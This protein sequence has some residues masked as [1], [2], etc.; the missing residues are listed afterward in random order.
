M[1]VPPEPRLFQPPI[2][3]SRMA[4]EVASEIVTSKGWRHRRAKVTMGDRG[5][6]GF[7]I[8]G[9]DGPDLINEV[10][11]GELQVAMSNPGSILTLALNG[12]G[13]F[14]EPVAVRAIT[15][16]QS[17]DQL[18]FAVKED[19]GITSIADI[20]EKRYPLRMSLR[21]QM[22]HSIHLVIDELLGAAGF[23]LDGIRSWGGEITFGP[24]IPN[25][26]RMD[27]VASGEV[28]AVCD[29]ASN[30][31]TDRAIDLGMR[32]LP[33]EGPLLQKLEGI[34][35]RKGILEKELY[36]GLD[37]DV[38]TLDYSGFILFT[39]AD[40]PDAEIRAVCEALEA[41]KHSIPRDTGEGPLPLDQM[42]R[43]T[44]AGPLDIPLHPAAEAF[45]REQGYLT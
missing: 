24:G 27:Q 5:D 21:A 20:L 18:V 17:Y 35:F 14:K 44:P 12:K 15:I 40:V 11:R 33:I 3:R 13:P 25:P 2:V 30:N 8:S 22:D 39:H 19:T 37:A 32:I 36:P 34:G 29:E 45:W 38:S 43:D 9:D 28:N 16:I 23:S 1:I 41:R 26:A 10:A 4:L 31:W 6:F 7:V 42:C